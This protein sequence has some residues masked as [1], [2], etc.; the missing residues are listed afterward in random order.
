MS[1]YM[2][3]VQFHYGFTPLCAIWYNNTIQNIIEN[4]GLTQISS[5]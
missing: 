3:L 1:A 5:E 2:N 4:T